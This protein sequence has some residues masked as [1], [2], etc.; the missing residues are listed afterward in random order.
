MKNDSTAPMSPALRS[1]AQRRA[2]A[3]GLVGDHQDLDALQLRQLARGVDRLDHPVGDVDHVRLGRLVDVD[4]DRWSPVH[5]PADRELGRD[6]LDGR[7]VADADATADDQVSHVVER[8]EL[9][10]RA[11]DE[12]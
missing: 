7:D 3:V 12:A 6:E 1:S 8:V 9:A 10:Q 4:A 2:D 5:A 11:N